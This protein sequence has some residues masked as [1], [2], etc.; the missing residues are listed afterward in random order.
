M[1]RWAVD[2]D[3]IERDPSQGIRDPSGGRKRERER[4]LTESEIIALWGICDE[5][6]YPWRRLV[7]LLLLTG[8]RLGEVGELPW[9]ELD[10]ERRVWSLPSSRTKNHR[11]HIVHLSELAVEVIDKIPRFDVSDLVFS[12]N[13][14]KPVQGYADTTLRID[15]Q[16]ADR[17]GGVEPWVTMIYAGPWPPIWPILMSRRTYW[18]GY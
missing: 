17:L 3:L 7:Q 12:R 10:L 8:Q 6:A 13:G 9:S 18:I 15:K 14:D 16:L 2:Q 4:V 11:P 1:F 5:L